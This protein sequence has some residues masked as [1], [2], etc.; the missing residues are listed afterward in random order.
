MPKGSDGTQLFNVAEFLSPQQITSYFSSLAAKV[1][2]QL[3]NDCDV[4]AS[5]EEI[6]FM[7]ARNLA[8]ETISL[9][10]PIVFDQFDICTMVKNDTLKKLKLDMLLSIC[11]NLELNVP[12]PVIRQKAPYLTLL[13]EAVSQCTCQIHQ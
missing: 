8:L 1:R 5:E 2:K 4:Q 10:H 13:G 12:V 6:N 7:M 3:P 11:Q 9:Q